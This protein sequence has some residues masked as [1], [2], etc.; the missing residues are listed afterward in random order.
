MN[1]VDAVIQPGWEAGLKLLF[2]RRD[3]RS[4]LAKR[5]SF[6]PL[7][8]QKSLH[9]E[10]D[11]VCHAILLHPPGGI[12]GGDRLHIDIE[13]D[14]E[15]HALL[16]TP[17]A[18]RWYRTLGARASQ[19]VDINIGAGGVCE[20]MPQENI[21]FNAARADNTLNI[22]LAQGAAFCGWDILCL[23]RT[24][25]GERFGTGR[26]R[27]HLNVSREA[28]PV[29]EELSLIEGGSAVLD[30]PAGMAGYPVCGTF[31]VAGV[32][33][34]REALEYCR[35]VVPQGDCK[36]GVSAMGELFVAR[37]LARSAEAARN[38]FLEM[39]QRLRP[40]YARVPAKVPRIWAT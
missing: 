3:E 7:A 24:A 15:A 20:W 27:Q 16:T 31:L 39:W 23:G 26:V 30:S 37:C 34:G 29:F 40:D 25:S 4:V 8:V 10:G 22:R 35:G 1:A 36:W 33:A 5:S 14:N 9:P 38:Y 28:G 12:A 17:G 6:G 19:T 13:I 11:K 2:Q 18:T 21:F 32:A